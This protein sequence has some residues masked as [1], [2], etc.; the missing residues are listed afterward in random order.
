MSILTQPGLTYANHGRQEAYQAAFEQAR[1]RSFV[2]GV[3]LM[4]L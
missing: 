3:I 2:Y 4:L 1:G